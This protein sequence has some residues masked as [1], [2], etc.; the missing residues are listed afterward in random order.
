MK[1]IIALILVFSMAIGF[2]PQ[3]AII[4]YAGEGDL[5]YDF[6]WQNGMPTD[7]TQITFEST[8]NTWKYQDKLSSNYNFNSGTTGIRMVADWNS[9][10]KK[11]LMLEINIPDS[12]RD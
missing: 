2:L 9:K 8:N 6:T 11:T 3:M 7:L 4:G 1:K 5:Y 12:P 10:T